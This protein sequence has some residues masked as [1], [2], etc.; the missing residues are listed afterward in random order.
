MRLEG[1][2]QGN[3]L[4]NKDGESNLSRLIP[5]PFPGCHDVR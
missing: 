2:G 3:M 5:T 4:E 1:N